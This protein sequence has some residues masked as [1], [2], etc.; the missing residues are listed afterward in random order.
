MTLAEIFAVIKPDFLVDTVAVSPTTY[1]ELDEKY[2]DFRSHLLV[3]C[4]VFDRDWSEWEKH[5][6]GD[7]IVVLLSGAARMRLRRSA[8][9]EVVDLT[10][11]GSFV[12]VPRDTWH[13][14]ETTVQTRMLFVTPGEG[15][16]NR[17]SADFAEDRP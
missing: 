13:T 12:V 11:A 6:A 2:D 16:E 10:E 5:P 17:A 7:E 4:H 8:G 15:T 3:S 1:A 14:A 9:E